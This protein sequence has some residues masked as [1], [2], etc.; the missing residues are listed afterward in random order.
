MSSDSITG[1]QGQFVATSVTDGLKI[2]KGD[3]TICMVWGGLHLGGRSVMDVCSM[4][5]DVGGR[6]GLRIPLEFVLV[7]TELPSETV[8]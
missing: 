3:S 6:K 4:N 1:S 5:L 8:L 2:Q 7:G